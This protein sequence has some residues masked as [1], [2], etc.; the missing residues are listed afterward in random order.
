MIHGGEMAKVRVLGPIEIEYE[1]KPDGRDLQPLEASLIVALAL[2][3]DDSR[4]DHTGEGG[5]LGGLTDVEIGRAVWNSGN[6]VRNVQRAINQI[7]SA[8][9]I[10]FSRVDSNRR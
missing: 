9:S 7:S 5:R 2:G 4:G 8:T 3:A 6:G 10:S 1:R